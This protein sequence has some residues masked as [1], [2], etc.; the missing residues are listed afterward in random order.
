MFTVGLGSI[1][2]TDDVPARHLVTLTDEDGD[3]SIKKVYATLADDARKYAEVL[4]DELPDLYTCGFPA[5]TVK[6]KKTDAATDE[7]SDEGSD[8][9]NDEE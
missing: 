4:C 2:A 3:I 9:G 6:T 1:K 7:G 8:E 5:K